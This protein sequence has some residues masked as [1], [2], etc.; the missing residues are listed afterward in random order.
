MIAGEIAGAPHLLRHLDQASLGGRDG[1]REPLRLG[2]AEQG[3][4]TIGFKLDHALSQR[5][6]PLRRHV[7]VGDENAHEARWPGLEVRG[8]DRRAVGVFGHGKAR[9]IEQAL[10]RGAWFVLGHQMKV[11]RNQQRPG[12][13]NQTHRSRERGGVR[14]E[15]HRSGISRHFPGVGGEFGMLL[16]AQD[17]GAER[18]T[19]MLFGRQRRWETA[20]FAELHQV[21]TVGL[22]QRAR[23]I[24]GEMQDA[25]RN[26]D[27]RER[28]G[29]NFAEDCGT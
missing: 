28:A 10:R 7:A 24:E 29:V 8:V 14:M 6:G 27:R 5:T 18:R 1:R 25:R 15:R 3:Q 12:L 4:R 23:G 2:Q 26:G 20:R 21:G 16:P 11:D 9:M 19:M 17:G 22:R 13:R